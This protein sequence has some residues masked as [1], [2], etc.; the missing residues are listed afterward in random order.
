MTIARRL[1]MLAGA[2]ALACAH[3]GLTAGTAAAPSDQDKAFGWPPTRA[4][5]PTRLRHRHPYRVAARRSY[6]KSAL[7]ARSSAPAAAPAWS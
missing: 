4:T 2:A 6:P 3:L 7:P 5:S 1:A